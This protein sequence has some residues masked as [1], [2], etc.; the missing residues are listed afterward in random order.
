MCKSIMHLKVYDSSVAI[1]VSC[2]GCC[3]ISYLMYSLHLRAFQFSTPFSLVLNLMWLVMKGFER[4]WAHPD[5]EQ[6]DPVV[7]HHTLLPALTKTRVLKNTPEQ[8][9]GISA[10]KAA[11]LV[12]ETPSS[13]ILRSTF[14]VNISAYG[15]TISTNGSGYW[16]PLCTT[17]L[18]QKGTFLEN[19]HYITRQR[20]IFHKHELLK[21]ILSVI[22]TWSNKF[23]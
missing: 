5:R 7:K 10:A 21:Y 8:F 22:P 18:Q 11:C 9:I 12:L 3:F 16:T 14:P 19:M 4:P 23:F 1:A 2:G 17:S 6:L 13:V 20:E 15:G